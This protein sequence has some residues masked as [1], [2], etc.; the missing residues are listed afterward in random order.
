MRYC[1][2]SHII[3]DKMQIFGGKA[4][5]DISCVK[6]I[7]AGD[8][9]N[10]FNFTMENHWGTHVDSPRHF[11][12]N[13]PKITD[14]PPTFWIF[15]RPTVL[16]VKLRPAELLNDIDML[17]TVPINTDL[18]LFRSG[19]SSC[20]DQDIYGKENPGIHPDVGL[21]IR[22]HFPK[23]KAIGIDWVS[24]SSFQN[25]ELGR[26]THRILLDP[27]GEGQPVLII[28]DMDLTKDLSLLFQVWAIPLRIAEV[29][30]TPCTVIGVLND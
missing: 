5:V 26:E 3:K 16:D 25:R 24:V 21:F 1:F 10:V 12:D 4:T 20:R 2:L 30:S 22:R 17:K 27:Q 9:S 19:W 14:Y 6:S 7:I 23:I 15:Q 13:G 11:F 29:D 28:E 8:S 18:L